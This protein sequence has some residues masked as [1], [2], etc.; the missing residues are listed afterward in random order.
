MS[1][2]SGVSGAGSSTSSNASIN[3]GGSASVSS[4]VITPKGD[5]SSSTVL[6]NLNSSSSSA[7][8]TSVMEKGISDIR[9]TENPISE[10]PEL[11]GDTE[12]NPVC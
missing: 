6:I 10:S 2:D 8:K 11:A 12:N 9:I 7:A 3:N 1:V 5:A 4:G